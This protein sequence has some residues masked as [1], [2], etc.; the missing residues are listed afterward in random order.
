M[1]VR[2]HV[3]CKSEVGEGVVASLHQ[4]VLELDVHMQDLVPLELFVALSAVKDELLD[5]VLAD[6]STFIDHPVVLLEVTCLAVVHDHVGKTL[7]DDAK[8]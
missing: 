4:D 7:R 1:I 8:R 6:A 5:L 2:V 3:D